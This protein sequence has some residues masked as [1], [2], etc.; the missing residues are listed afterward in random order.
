VAPDGRALVV[1]DLSRVRLLY[2]VEGEAS[3][4]E[5]TLTEG[6]YLGDVAAD[7]KSVVFAE[8]G[9][10]EGASY[11]AYLRRLDEALPVRLG[12]G[13][14]LSISADG[15]KVLALRY[16][17]PSALVVLPTGAGQEQTLGRGSLASY[18]WARWFSDGRRV[19]I[20]GAEAGR[21][22]R[23]WSQEADASAPRPLT[24]EGFCPAAALSPDGGR[25]LAVDDAGHLRFFEAEGGRL[26][27]EAP[28]TFAGLT[29]LAWGPGDV[30]FL[31]TRA[32]P[33]RIVRVELATGQ[34]SPHLGPKFEGRAGL[35]SIFALAVS[36]DGKSYAY[37]PH[38]I[39]SRLF[40][41]EGL[42]GPAAQ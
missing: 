12:E 42:G 31:R 37:S 19:L 26:V 24:P 21:P 11:G 1:S 38:E 8:V 2:G 39:R 6:S 35:A 34:L 20:A 30:A 14:P 36:P 23:L 4:R 7:G 3:E 28:G 17:A 16:G 13:W 29:V 40:L 25:F 32:M 18:Q 9:A 33:A 41:A 15:T 22:P 27:G 5:L 10:G